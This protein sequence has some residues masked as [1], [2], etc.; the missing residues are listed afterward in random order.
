M[1]QPHHRYGLCPP[2]H[3]LRRSLRVAHFVISPQNMIVHTES[4]RAAQ[5]KLDFVWHH[6]LGNTRDKEHVLPRT[7]L[8]RIIDMHM[9]WSG[10]GIVRGSH[11]LHG[12]NRNGMATPPAFGPLARHKVSCGKSRNALVGC[13]AR[14]CWRYSH[15][16]TLQPSTRLVSASMNTPLM[17]SSITRTT[18]RSSLLFNLLFDSPVPLFVVTTA[19]LEG[20][21][22][23]V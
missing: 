8:E 23:M 13:A 9:N 10:C 17:S 19:L 4:W 15:T 18:A 1:R 7:E 5:R 22:I 11:S 14:P 2:C 12:R 3:R 6:I 20:L 21:R 16:R